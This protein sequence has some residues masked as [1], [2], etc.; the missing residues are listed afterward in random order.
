MAFFINVV[1][2]Q[3][4]DLENAI[5]YLGLER[6]D[7]KTYALPNGNRLELRP[8][9]AGYVLEPPPHAMGEA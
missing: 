5:L 4:E 2:F 6:L 1:R 9:E 3:E 7:R 8:D